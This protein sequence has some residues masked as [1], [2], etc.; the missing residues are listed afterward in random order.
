[1]PL[2]VAAFL[3]ALAVI[4]T[5][6]HVVQQFHQYE[7]FDGGP[8]PRAERNPA[9][10]VIVPVRNERRN[11]ER[12]LRGLIHQNYP[13]GK[14]RIIVADDDSSDGTRAIVRRLTREC[15]RIDLLEPAALPQ[16]WVGKSHA[17]WRG[18]QSAQAEWLCF[19]D[20]DTAAAPALIATA[21]GVALQRDLDLVSLEPF[22]ELT[23]FFDRLAIPLG[24]LAIAAT[25]RLDKGAVNGQF[26]LVRAKSYFLVGGH[27]SNPDAICEDAALARAVKDAGG[28]VAVIGGEGLISTRMYSGAADLWEGLSKNLTEIYGGSART[29]LT[30]FGAFA[31]G[32]AALV[33]PVLAAFDVAGNASPEAVLSLALAAPSAAIVLAMQIALVRHFRIPS[34]YGLLLPLSATVGAAIAVNAVLCRARGRV[35]WKGRVYPAGAPSPQAGGTKRAA[36]LR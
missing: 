10:A 22:Q 15:D 12:C 34:W 6:R 5:L 13:S 16:E 24:F 32:W 2:A 4:L 1:M 8:A 21:L 3:L 23:G 18:A 17:C 20:A 25:Q 36:P 31:I 19:V 14:L 29:L 9:I 27:A 7:S 33:L 26:L 11:I 35:A 30:A 28:R